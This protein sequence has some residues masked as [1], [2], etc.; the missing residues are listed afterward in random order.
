M[1]ARTLPAPLDSEANTLFNSAFC[2]L[3]LN[4]ATADYE[5]KTGAAMPIT[6]AFLVLPSAL[7]KPTRDALPPTTAYSMWSWIRSNP[8]LLMDFADRIRTF[9]PYT[10]A[11]ITFGIR[12]G[13][14]TGSHGAISPGTVGRRPRTLLPTED[15][16]ACLKAAA[17]LG[18]WF[19]GTGADEATTLAQ[20]GVRP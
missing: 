4:R 17:F 9:R 8:V 7:H 15:W 11:A 12:H 18:R 6:F 5:A 19:G 10:G 1:N 14:L 20:W 16:T 3:M 2:A 13:A